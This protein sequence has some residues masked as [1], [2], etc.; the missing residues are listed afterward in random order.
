MHER[1]FALLEVLVAAAL[2][3]VLAVGISRVLAAAAHE[4]QASRLRALATIA[5]AAKLEEL[6]AT[7]PAGIEGGSDYVDE[8][9]APV[10]SGTSAPPRAVF[11][12]RWSVRPLTAD[13]RTM[14]L[15]VEMWTRD[16]AAAASLATVRAGR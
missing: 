12:R 11:L 6:R 10:G 4:R 5:A 8:A 1:G 7:P 16:G 14:A 3:V 2:L 9:G 13:A 15:L